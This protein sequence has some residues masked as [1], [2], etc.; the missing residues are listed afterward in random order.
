MSFYPSH[1]PHLSLSFTVLG[2]VLLALSL[3]TCLAKK[4]VGTI[5]KSAYDQTLTRQQYLK[6]SETIRNRSRRWSV[7]LGTL[8]LIAVWNSIALVVSLE[9]TI[10]NT[11]S[12]V[13]TQPITCYFDKKMMK[14]T[15][16]IT[17]K[18]VFTH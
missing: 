2:A 13:S 18:I 10:G 6:V 4:E 17:K 7:T 1:L 16:K 11:L 3:E 9:Y 5:I 14:K 12:V 15:Q 8:V